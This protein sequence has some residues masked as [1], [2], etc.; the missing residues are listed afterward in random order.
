[1][2]F[3]LIIKKTIEMLVLKYTLPEN[4]HK[5]LSWVHY[6]GRRCSGMLDNKYCLKIP[7][8]KYPDFV[9]MYGQLQSSSSVKLK[10]K[11]PLT[12]FSDLWVS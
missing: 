10:N 3:L 4:A 5:K 7:G 12:V 9:H 2:A 6:E 8:L 11:V 1:M